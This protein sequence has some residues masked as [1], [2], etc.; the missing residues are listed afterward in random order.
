MGL[1]EGRGA[2][3]GARLTNGYE[4]HGTNWLELETRGKLH[5]ARTSAAEAG[6]SSSHVRSLRGEATA[7][8]VKRQPAAILSHGR[9]SRGCLNRSEG[10]N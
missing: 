1:K 8:Q 10:M 4:P 9:A 3:L 7:A 5:H 2:A 6:I